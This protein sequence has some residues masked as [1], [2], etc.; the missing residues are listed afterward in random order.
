MI[1]PYTGKVTRALV[2]IPDCEGDEDRCQV[3]GQGFGDP[4]SGKSF[5]AVDVGLSVATGHPFHGREVKQG[6][7]FFIA[8][9]GHNGLARRFH[10]WSRARGVTL[11]GVPLFK[12]E[13][14]AQ[15]LDKDSAQ[16]VAQSVQELASQHGDPT[17]III[18]TLARNFG[19]GD[20]SS[21]RDMSEFIAAVDELKAQFTG[22]TVLIIHHSGHADKQRARGAMALKGALD[23][24]YRIEKQDDQ[25]RLVCTKM[26]DAPEPDDL[27]FA[28][29]TVQID[30]ETTS[31]VL[32]E[33]DASERKKTL[34]PSQQLGLITFA[35]AAA[36]DPQFDG[37][38]PLSAWLSAFLNRHTGDNEDSKKRAFRRT[39][40]DMVQLGI[41]TV[42][43]DTYRTEN[44][45][46]LQMVE[47]KRTDRT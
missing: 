23:F 1:L 25:M 45:Q 21:T 24:E 22:C 11:E 31:A 38:L 26:K 43:N 29:R 3:L 33:T 40:A 34:T 8:G 2:V 37:E 20:E 47:A 10:A 30:H 46:L 27:A 16:A 4:A 7:V 36:D 19:A 39:R 12:S 13:R 32:E 9:E 41:L 44:A 28:F 15:F 14:A 6:A 18:D 17:L 35:E 5:V 42:E